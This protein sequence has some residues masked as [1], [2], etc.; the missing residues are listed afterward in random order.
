LAGTVEEAKNLVEHGFGYVTDV[1]G[2]KSFG[3]LK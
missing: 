2:M 1:D 3:I